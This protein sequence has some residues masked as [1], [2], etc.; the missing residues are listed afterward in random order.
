MEAFYPHA[1][2][3]DGRL[4]KCSACT[5]RDV[6]LNRAMKIEKYQQYDRDR[7]RLPH[8]RANAVAQAI[9]LKRK[10]GIDWHKSHNAVKRAIAAGIITR[11]DSCESCGTNKPV[12]AHHDNHRLNLMVMWLCSSCHA[13]RHVFLKKIGYQK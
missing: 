1:G 2:M 10:H 4:N 6:A 11:P 13:K 12:Q 3:S 9:R 7:A 8:R 5:R